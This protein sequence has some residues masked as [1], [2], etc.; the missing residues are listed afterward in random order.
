MLNTICVYK[1]IQKEILNIETEHI[2]P[3][4]PSAP[5]AL[6]PRWPMNYPTM[7]NNKK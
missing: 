2:T 3:G 7:E 4:L 5:P 6:Q 1:M